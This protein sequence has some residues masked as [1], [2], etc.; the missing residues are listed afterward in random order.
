MEHSPVE[1]AVRLGARQP[2]STCSA[3]ACDR[4]WRY[5]GPAD[6]ALL[7]VSP[8]RDK[9]EE[10]DPDLRQ[11]E[12]VKSNRVRKGQKIMLRWTDG[13]FVKET[14]MSASDSM[15]RGEARRVFLDLLGELRRQGRRVTPSSGNS[16]APAIFAAEPDAKRRQREGVRLRNE[17]AASGPGCGDI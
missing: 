10:H 2:G 3:S 1:P 17:R 11:L 9:G 5:A 4:A 7:A 16:Y 12:L 8:I 15:A 14:P 13:V 6:R